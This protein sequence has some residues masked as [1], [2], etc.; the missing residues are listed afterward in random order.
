MSYSAAIE[1]IS[2]SRQADAEAYDA[3]FLKYYEMLCVNAY[4]YLKDAEEARELVQDFFVELF[5]KKRYADLE[6]D[7]KGYLYQSVKNRCLNRLR[8]MENDKKRLEQ[9]KLEAMYAQRSGERAQTEGVYN[10]LHEAFGQLSMQ[11]KEALTLVYVQDKRYQEAAEK[12][13]ISVNSLKTH[14]K[15]GLKK[16]RQTLTNYRKI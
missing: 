13:G 8:K 10:R 14:L 9:L 12:M 7:I 15:L 6:G 4:F 5:E 3:I 16:L 2:K 1:G 11:R